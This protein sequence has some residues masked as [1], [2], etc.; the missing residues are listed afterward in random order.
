MSL[1]LLDVWLDGKLLPKGSDIIV[2]I[3]GLH[4]DE[5]KYVAPEVFNPGRY[6][7]KKG[8][9]DEYAHTA[10]Y[11]ARDHYAYGVGRRLCPGIHLAERTVFLITAK[12]L[13]AFDF[14]GKVDANG[15][16]HEIDISSTTGY[17]DGLTV[18]PKA[19]PCDIK[20]RSDR[21]KATILR[22]FAEVERDIFPNFEIPK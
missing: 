10:D 16:R 21:T 6:L 9:A 15:K 7:D 4:H 14:Q 19:F 12:L 1:N 22:E 11:E 13:W 20:V 2:N 18:G 8:L 17:T 5:T 3:Y